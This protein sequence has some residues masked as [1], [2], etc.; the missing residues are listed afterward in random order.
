M[1]A[2]GAFQKGWA[3]P[4]LLRAGTAIFWACLFGLFDG[5]PLPFRC[6][7]PQ[8]NRGPT[9]RE[10]SWVAAVAL[11]FPK[12]HADPFFLLDAGSA[13]RARPFWE[14]FWFSHGTHGLGEVPTPNIWRTPCAKG[15]R[16]EQGASSSL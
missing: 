14:D 5:E 3:T 13:K 10:E 8:G 1:R 9:E 16:W 6:K 11:F 15:L 7:G 4:F 12:R 2:S